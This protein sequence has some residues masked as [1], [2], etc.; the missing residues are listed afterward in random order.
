MS[1]SSKYQQQPSLPTMRASEDLLI[2]L[3]QLES[4]AAAALQLGGH[5]SDLLRVVHEPFYDSRNGG[6]APTRN[7]IVF[8]RDILGQRI[9][10]TEH[11]VR[12]TELAYR[13]DRLLELVGDIAEFERRTS[14]TA[15][16][17]TTVW[18][19]RLPQ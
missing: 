4:I 18:R 3:A 1:T 2:V 13:F 9:I 14:D 10:V 19:D 6:D 15:Y 8:G 17:Q 5:P 16:Y 7:L 11:S 12:R